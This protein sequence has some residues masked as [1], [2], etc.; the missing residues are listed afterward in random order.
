MLRKMSHNF[1]CSEMYKPN[2]WWIN[3][4]ENEGVIVSSGVKVLL[5][6]MVRVP[7]LSNSKFNIMQY[8]ELEK[9]CLGDV[10]DDL[11]LAYGEI[12]SYIDACALCL[13]MKK[14]QMAEFGLDSLF[15][16]HPAFNNARMFITNDQVQMIDLFSDKPRNPYLTNRTGFAYL[17]S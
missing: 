15:I 3:S 4:L 17:A 10:A 13:L 5:T 14:E 6:V 2:A 8:A 7:E 1:H 9:F 12:P 16:M 11:K